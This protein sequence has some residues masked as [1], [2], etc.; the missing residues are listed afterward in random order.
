M[1]TRNT[2]L[3]RFKLR[4]KVRGKKKKTSY[5]GSDGR[6]SKPTEENVPES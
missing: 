6:N 5:T 1:V 2:L 3:K 4:S